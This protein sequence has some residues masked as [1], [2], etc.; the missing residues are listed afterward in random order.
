M[1]VQ[2]RPLDFLKTQK[3]GLVYIPAMIAPMV[4][5]DTAKRS[6]KLVEGTFEVV[7][8]PPEDYDTAAMRSLYGKLPPL[9]Q[10]SARA[11]AKPVTEGV[12]IALDP[13]TGHIQWRQRGSYFWDGGVMS[14]AGNIV[15]QGD[16][17]GYLNIFAAD[18]GKL[19]RSIETGTSIMAAPMTYAVDGRQYIAVMAGFGGG[20]GFSFP[21]DSAAYKY[22]NAGRILVFKLGGG[23]VPLPSPVK[24]EPIPQ[25]PAILAVSKREIARGSIL[26]NRYCSRCHVFG[27]GLL[28]DLRRIPPE[29]HD[30]FND[31]V[32]HGIFASVGMARFSD[33]LTSN[34]AKAIHAYIIDQATTAANAKNGVRVVIPPSPH[35]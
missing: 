21:P 25:P 5:I 19:L 27:R 31:I 10:L 18:S 32:L 12:L 6:A 23:P 4:Y 34:D 26:Y 8:I 16:V 24:S 33:V 3:T 14:T 1:T 28:P 20:G 17:K 29:I 9:S 30:A 7:G 35:H 13:T 22:G 2:N 15:V 11:P